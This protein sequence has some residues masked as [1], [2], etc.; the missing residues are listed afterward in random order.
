MCDMYLT[1]MLMRNGMNFVP[2]Y[3]NQYYLHRKASDTTAHFKYRF[4]KKS[5]YAILSYVRGKSFTRRRP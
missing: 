5:D 3:C 1:H 2:L 4:I